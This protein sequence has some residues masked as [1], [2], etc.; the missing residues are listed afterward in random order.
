MNEEENEEKIEEEEEEKE[1]KVSS[2]RMGLSPRLKRLFFVLIVLILYAGAS[3]YLTV[4]YLRKNPEPFGL[5]K[6]AALLKIEEKEIVDKISKSLAL[7]EGEDPT[8]A[9]VTDPEKLSGQFFF[10]DAKK[11]DK[12]LIYQNAKKVILYRPSENRVVEVGVVD[13]DKQSGAN[14]LNTSVTV[15]PVPSTASGNLLQKD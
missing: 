10:K 6:G 1:E 13:L 4:W 5:L 15:T 12:L 7:P 9:T 3:S 14:S 11:G 2:K 8:M